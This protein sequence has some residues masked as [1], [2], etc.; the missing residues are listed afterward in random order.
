MANEN[1]QLTF[2][3]FLQKK[4]SSYQK[5]INGM[6][7]TVYDNHASISSELFDSLEKPTAVDY[8]FVKEFNMFYIR[9]D[10]DGSILS[11]KRSRNQFGCKDIKNGLKKYYPYDDKKYFLR[12][13]NGMERGKYYVFFP[14]NFELVEKQ[15]R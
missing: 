14:E 1:M 6:T 7:I 9:A 10:E 11:T 2:E 3:S 12:M 15:G 4:N 5:R 13:K 8:G